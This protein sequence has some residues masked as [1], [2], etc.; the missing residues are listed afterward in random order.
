MVREQ[1]WK[2]IF[3][4]NGGREQLFDMEND[5][6]ELV[7]RIDENRDISLRLR[8]VA[9]SACRAAGEQA[10]L[11]QDDLKSFPYSKHEAKRVYQFDASRG[12]SGFPEKPQDV[13]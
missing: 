12:V 6:N 5:P 11:E 13:L 7:N 2:Y 1:R 3:I 9:A 4:A 8:S 10:A